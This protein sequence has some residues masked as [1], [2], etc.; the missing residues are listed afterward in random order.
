MKISKYKKE[1]GA[2][3][4]SNEFK[5]GLK[6][7]CFQEL[8]IPKKNNIKIYR[9]IS[10]AA[11]LVLAVSAVG[12]AALTSEQKLDFAAPES[13][14]YQSND[15]MLYAANSANQESVMADGI[16]AEDSVDEVMEKSASGNGREVEEPAE[17]DEIEKETAESDDAEDTAT[18]TKPIST[19][20]ASSNDT[21]GETGDAY[22]DSGEHDSFV[23]TVVEVYETHYVVECGSITSGAVNQG[24]LVRVSK[25][26]EWHQAQNVEIGS[27]VKVV[28]DCVMETYPLQLGSVLEIRLLDENGYIVE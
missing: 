18:G 3:S 25:K 20:T 11:C 23:G 6:Q 1:V 26:V 28:F 17:S 22:A 15:A 9:Y 4:L 5:E 16:S 14:G 12:I 7:K 19:N 13:N 21:Y 27:T 10:I 8:E 2:L 24:A